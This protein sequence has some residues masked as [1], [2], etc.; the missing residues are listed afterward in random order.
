[1]ARI[2]SVVTGLA[3]KASDRRASGVRAGPAAER[4]EGGHAAGTADVLLNDQSVAAVLA[5]Q[6]AVIR[7]S[8]DV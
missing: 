8:V 5:W 4:R 2:L 1:M 3:R 7:S 6:A